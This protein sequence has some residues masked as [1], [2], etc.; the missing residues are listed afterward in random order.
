[1]IKILQ[2]VIREL[3]IHRPE[4]WRLEAFQSLVEA[5]YQF[6]K[7]ALKLEVL[8]RTE[9]GFLSVGHPVDAHAHRRLEIVIAQNLAQDLGRNILVASQLGNQ[10]HDRG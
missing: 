4:C 2:Q 10:T 8:Q 1:M 7:R 3:L 9:R 5:R 6:L